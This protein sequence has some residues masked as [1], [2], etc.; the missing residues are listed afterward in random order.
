[1]RIMEPLPTVEE[2]YRDEICLNKSNTAD[3]KTLVK[4]FRKAYEKLDGVDITSE[5]MKLSSSKEI[6]AMAVKCLEG[7]IAADPKTKQKEVPAANIL[8][9][10]ERGSFVDYR[11]ERSR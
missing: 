2:I 11:R 4:L 8:W 1:M 9:V 6:R 5:P 3:L 10:R 7:G